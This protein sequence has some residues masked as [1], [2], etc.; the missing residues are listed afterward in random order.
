MGIEQ[1]LADLLDVKIIAE[2]EELENDGTLK[3]IPLRNTGMKLY[4]QQDRDTAE[5]YRLKTALEKMITE[6]QPMRIAAAENALMRKEISDIS[7][8]TNSPV[9]RGIALEYEFN[10]LAVVKAK[11]ALLHNDKQLVNT[12]LDEHTV[13]TS[14][15]K[16]IHRSS[17]SVYIQ[18]GELLGFRSTNYKLIVLGEEILDETIK[19]IISSKLSWLDRVLQQTGQQLEAVFE[20]IPD[21]FLR[22]DAEGIILDSRG[23]LACGFHQHTEANFGKSIYR[24]ILPDV[25]EQFRDAIQISIEDG[26]RKTIEFSSDRCGNVMHYEARFVP[27]SEPQIVIIIRDITQQKEIAETQRKLVAKVES[28]NDELKDFAYIV[29][30]DL[31]APLR[32]I[33]SIAEWLSADYSDK[34]DEGGK[35]MLDLLGNRV[36]RMHNLIEGVLA[37]SRVGRV[38]EERSIVDLRRSLNEVVDILDIPDSISVSLPDE[39]PR[40]YIGKTRIEQVFQNLIGNAVK[41]MDK[42]EGSVEVLCEETESE[43]KFCIQDNGPGIPEKHLERVFR[44]FQTVSREECFE[45]TGVGLSIIKKIVEN[46]GG[47]VWVESEVGAGSSFYF[48][49]K[50]T[51]HAISEVNVEPV[52]DPVV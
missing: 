23:K 49:L 1:L 37:Y 25:A 45:S 15:H 52:T 28:I 48:S 30:H 42:P 46:Y 7:K 29:S 41:Y 11:Y 27:L 18:A 16:L 14:A 51:E 4:V 10:F 38:N 34:L 26:S 22:V 17:F 35:E 44:I 50:K 8:A 19:Q 9:S 43:W 36:M 20:V 47:R 39:L 6:I 3:R 12:G 31:K 40:I 24:I 21:L 32:S 33:R 13:K 2:G 5:V